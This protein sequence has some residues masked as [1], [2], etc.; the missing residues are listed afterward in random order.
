MPHSPH[1]KVSIVRNQLK[2]FCCIA[3]GW[4]LLRGPFCPGSLPYPDKNGFI[5]RF[6]LSQKQECLLY[7][8]PHTLEEV[9]AS[10]AAYRQH[11]NTER[12]HQSPRCRNRPPDVAF[13]EVP[14]RSSL[15]DM[16]DPDGWI[17]A[18]DGRMYVRKVGRNGSVKLDDEQYWPGK[19]YAGQY[20]L[21][22]IEAATRSFVIEDA[23][24]VIRSVPI[25]TVG[26]GRCSRQEW[27]A[28]LVED[29]KREDAKRRNKRDQEK[30]D[31]T[32]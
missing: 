6:H 29:A 5:E 16:V 4:N 17:T 1:A 20:V 21:L 3:K 23:T 18:W 22:Q 13:P 24:K 11:Y 12:P 15:P 25:R 27:L 31:L 28:Q 9:Q 10:V 26:G 32:P 2:A 8:R 7:D 19:A 14:A 30:K